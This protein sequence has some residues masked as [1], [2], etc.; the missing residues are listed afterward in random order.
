MLDQPVAGEIPLT[1]RRC[2]T[3]TMKPIAW[4]QQNTFLTCGVC[5]ASSLIDKDTC[6]GFLA[7]QEMRQP[8]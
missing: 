6:A 7:R 1:C 8:P 2:R 5:Y 3:V 4:L